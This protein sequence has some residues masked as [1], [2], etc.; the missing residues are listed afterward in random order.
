L[1]SVAAQT[2]VITAYQNT[3]YTYSSGSPVVRQSLDGEVLSPFFNVT[4][5]NSTQTVSLYVYNAE[6][7][8]INFPDFTSGLTGVTYSASGPNGDDGTYTTN[9]GTASFVSLQQAGTNTILVSFPTGFPTSGAVTSASQVNILGRVLSNLSAVTVY[10]AGNPQGYPAGSFSF[11][12]T[13]QKDASGNG[14]PQQLTVEVDGDWLN[15]LHIFL[16]PAPN[17]T[18]QKPTGATQMTPGALTAS[19]F[20]NGVELYLDDG[21]ILKYTGS[22]NTANNYKPLISMGGGTGTPLNAKV[23]G[24]GIMDGQAAEAYLANGSDGETCAANNQQT[25]P[26]CKQTTGTLGSAAAGVSILTLSDLATSSSRQVLVD[27]IVLRNSAAFNF[28]I[29]K[30]QGTSSY[31]ITVNNIKILGYSGATPGEGNSDG[32]DLFT[33]Q[34][35]N[36]TSSFFRTADDLIVLYQNNGSDTTLGLYPTAGINVVGNTLWNEYARAI[37]VGPELYNATNVNQ[38]SN[39]LAIDDV[40]FDSNTIIR[41]TGKGW[42]MGIGNTFGGK[43]QNVTFSNNTVNQA[44]GLFYIADSPQNTTDNPGI[45]GGSLFCNINMTVPQSTQRTI[46]GTGSAVEPFIGPVPNIQEAILLPSGDPYVGNGTDS[47][48]YP[49]AFQYPPKMYNVTVNGSLVNT[50]VDGNNYYYL[51]ADGAESVNS[52]PMPQN[53]VELTVAIRSNADPKSIWAY[54]QSQIAGDMYGPQFFSSYS[55]PV[56]TLLPVAH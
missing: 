11:N 17:S 28:T 27:G 56:S 31:P 22:A 21:A 39:P 2:N 43:V 46:I 38:P 47:G 10:A 37:A 26:F 49:M 9:L 13:A 29:N 20:T 25:A 50:A 52:T 32:L 7:R 35:A 34:Y 55:C 45:L 4:A 23:H 18:N 33:V 36:I 51:A 19:N 5:L 30:S 8:S 14:I 53:E 1:A 16:N 54:N 48:T 24:W 42:V 12:V 44:N 15:S 40:T 41:D 6:V 3:G